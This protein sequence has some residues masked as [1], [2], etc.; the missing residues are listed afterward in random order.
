MNSVYYTIEPK[1]YGDHRALF[2]SNN[3]EEANDVCDQINGISDRD[4]VRVV[5][6]VFDK[7]SKDF[8][9]NIKREVCFRAK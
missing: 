1:L 8:I 4:N 9:E 6:H 3:E 5:K 7:S 2:I